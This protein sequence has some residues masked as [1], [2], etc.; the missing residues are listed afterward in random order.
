MTDTTAPPTPPPPANTSLSTDY[1]VCKDLR[2]GYKANRAVISG[3][4]TA[5]GKG[6]VC[7]LIGPNAAGKTTLLRLLL[8]Q[9]EPWSG[10]VALDGRN[11]TQAA[12]HQRAEWIGY[13]PQHATA[14][15]A[16]TVEETVAMG[17]HALRED[18]PAV[19]HAL[20]VCELTGL[21]RCV[22]GHLSA[23]Q[24]QRVLLARAMA[25][26]AGGGRVM[27]LDE[28]VSSMDLKH[29]EQTMRAL[30]GL[31]AS[32]LAVLIALHDLNLAARYADEVWLM[33]RGGM[34]AAGP[35][36]R[37]LVP[38]V[39]EPVYEV[40]LRALAGGGRGRP[41]FCVDPEKNGPEQPQ[42]DTLL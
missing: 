34:A 39:L 22:Y 41:I 19:E 26:L 6:R 42:S 36:D 29:V 2:F 25:Q 14:S 13:V 20:K 37:V 11:V 12:P 17:R 24:Q 16:F 35:W 15:F 31:A 38:S 1:L 7:A 9:L 40:R 28:P 27:L 18:R 23:G 32:G 4:S 33:Q 8:G 10:S 3:V 21:R 30:R 5:L